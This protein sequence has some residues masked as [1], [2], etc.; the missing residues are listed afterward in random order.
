MPVAGAPRRAD[1][2]PVAIVVNPRA[3][4][5]GRAEL[6]PWVRRRPLVEGE[7]LEQA[8][9][10]VADQGARTIGV[11][12]GDGSQGCAAGVAAERG[13]ALLP[14]AGGTLNHFARTVG[15]DDVPRSLAAV[16]DGLVARIDL[17]EAGGRPFV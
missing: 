12:G 13:A 16:R 3:G 7:R 11:L 14:L 6:P 5:A 15:L 9:H 1:L 8:L 17:A 10:E 2:F 4:G